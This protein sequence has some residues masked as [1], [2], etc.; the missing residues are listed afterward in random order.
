MLTSMIDGDNNNSHE[1]SQEQLHSIIRNCFCCLDLI[2]TPLHVCLIFGL[3][4]AISVSAM[5]TG[6]NTGSRTLFVLTGTRLLTKP[7]SSVT[8]PWDFR[9]CL[10]FGGI[11]RV[12]LYFFGLNRPPQPRA[13]GQLW[14]LPTWP[15]FVLIVSS[16]FRCLSILSN[17]QRNTTLSA[18]CFEMFYVECSNTVFTTLVFLSGMAI[19]HFL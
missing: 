17:S 7:K 1:L 16:P 8:V 14:F 2:P 19:V 15:R 13:H 12:V 18:S 4:E 3:F 10:S 11:S 9:K 6:F 5:A